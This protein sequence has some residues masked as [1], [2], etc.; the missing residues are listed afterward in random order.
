V[1]SAILTLAKKESGMPR[2]AFRGHDFQLQ[3]IFSELA[4]TDEYPILSTFVFADSG[5]E[6]YSPVLNESVS[7]LQL[8]GLI[9]RENPDY[10]VLFLRPSAEQFFHEV[11]EHEFSP[12]EIDQLRRIA[13]VFLKRVTKVDAPA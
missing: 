8:S 11:L 1:L 4:R 13:S 7:R 3:E 10:E 2:F 12:V 5:P 9:G 6:P